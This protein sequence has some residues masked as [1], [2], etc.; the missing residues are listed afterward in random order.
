M[1]NIL[2]DL[3]CH[4]IKEYPTE[5]RAALPNK[6]N[7]TAVTVKKDSLKI[8]I[9]TGEGNEFGDIFTLI[10]AINKCT[11]GKANKYLHNTLGLK[12]SYK[13]K[14]KNVQIDPLLIFKKIKRKKFCANEDIPV[15]NLS[16]IQE[17][18]PL[19]HIDWIRDGIMPFAAERF[20]IGYSFDKKRIIIPERKWDGGDN[21]FI[22]I[23][24]R[25][26]VPMWEGLGLS[27]Y[28]AIQPY[29][30]SRNVYGL[31]ENY[32]T[33]QEQGF[34]VVAEA[35]KSVLKRYSRKDGTVVSIGGCE[36][37]SEQ[38]KILIG[39]NV[40]IVL[41]FDEGIS[42]QHI[43]RECE[44]FYGIRKISYIYDKHNLIKAGSKDSPCD[45]PNKQYQFLFKYRV[46]YD[47]KEHGE[48]I[49]WREK[50]TMN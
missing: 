49:K 6:E 46:D 35:Q 38:V 31:N 19:L 34:V 11:F 40:E 42:L 1:G 16:L 41:C 27:K 25:T 47:E 32:K 14:Q 15:Y 23:M 22:G 4:K 21:D 17:Y 7:A 13:S 36:L 28:Y 18:S 48:Y 50:H 2:N 20:H 12:Y 10:M 8:S 44:K 37:S 24:G 29:S 30:K 39:L 33:I 9:R 45:L 26:T 5:Y 3:K 43:R